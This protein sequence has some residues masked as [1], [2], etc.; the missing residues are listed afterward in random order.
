MR[1]FSPREVRRMMQRLGMEMQELGDVCKVVFYMSG[2]Q[3][4]V[5]DPQVMVMKIGGQTIYQVMGGAVEVM[6]KEK[7]SAPTFTEEDVQLVAA[8]AG[9]SLEEARKALE[10]TQGDLAQAILL[11]TSK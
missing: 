11:L 1:K 2:K 6:E 7:P 8:Q 9:V 5:E 4:V 10:Q 3:L